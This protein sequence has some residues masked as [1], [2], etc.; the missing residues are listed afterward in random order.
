MNLGYVIIYVEHVEQTV[1]FY[2]AAFSI[3]RR[4]VHESG[5][6]AEMET[7]N[8]ALAFADESFSP[9]NGAIRLNRATEPAAGAEITFVAENVQQSFDHAVKAGAVAVLEPTRKPWDQTVAY[10]RDLNGFL[11]EICD[12]VGG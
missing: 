8:T 10:V 1:S 4:F 3:S 9:L 11:V 6:Y 7:G 5:T 2:E 12:K